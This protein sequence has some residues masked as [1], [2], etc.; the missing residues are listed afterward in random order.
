MQA[1]W[2]DKVLRGFAEVF[3]GASAMRETLS[4]RIGR[5]P[6]VVPTSSASPVG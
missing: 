5:V 6:P 2:T 3:G 1:I 4:R